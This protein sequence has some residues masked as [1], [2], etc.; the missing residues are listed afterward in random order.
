MNES[1]RQHRAQRAR[2]LLG[3]DLFA[4]ALTSIR[5]EALL[6]LAETDP[7][8]KT[9]IIRQQAIVAVTGMIVE[10]LQAVILQSG[11]QDGGISVSQ[12]RKEAS[13]N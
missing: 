5:S 10:M 6:E 3:D 7:D 8:D 2:E 4:E 9:E 12:P 13:I 11:E 1:E